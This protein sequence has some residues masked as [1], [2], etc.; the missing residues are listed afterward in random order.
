MR[1]AHTASS[2]VRPVRS[3]SLSQ[4]THK[5]YQSYQT[6]PTDP[7]DTTPD[8]PPPNPPLD[9]PAHACSRLGHRLALLFVLALLALSIGAATAQPGAAELLRNGTFEGGS[10]PNGKGGGVPRWVPVDAGY[11]IDRTTHHGGD[12]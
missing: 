3:V 9:T 4:P 7:T 10:G 1:I 5:S 12:Q 8:P 2:Q 11:D 6:D